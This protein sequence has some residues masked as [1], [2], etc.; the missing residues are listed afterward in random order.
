M[1]FLK[2][3]IYSHEINVITVITVKKQKNWQLKENAIKNM[4]FF[5]DINVN[6]VKKIVSKR[7]IL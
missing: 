1:H 3:I 6:K 4:Y 2:T 5:V 7:S